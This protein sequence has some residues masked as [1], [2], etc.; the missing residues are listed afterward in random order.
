MAVSMSKYVAGVDFLHLP[1]LKMNPRRMHSSD[2]MGSDVALR[3]LGTNGALLPGS[4]C[5]W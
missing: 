5:Q 3:M 4:Q 1:I 2:P